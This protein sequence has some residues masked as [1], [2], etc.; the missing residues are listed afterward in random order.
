[1]NSWQTL[2]LFILA[3]C[4]CVMAANS[5]RTGEVAWRCDCGTAP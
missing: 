1:M 4:V 2:F 5:I 3:I